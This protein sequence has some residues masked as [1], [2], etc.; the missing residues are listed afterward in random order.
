[1]RAAALLRVTGKADEMWMDESGWSLSLSVKP[2]RWQTWVW[3]ASKLWVVFSHNSGA[4]YLLYLTDS[5][6]DMSM[7]SNH[8]CKFQS[9]FTFSSISY[10]DVK[11]IVWKKPDMPE[12]SLV[13]VSV[14]V[15]GTTIEGHAL[16]SPTP[17]FSTI[18]AACLCRFDSW[19]LSNS[20]MLNMIDT[21]KPWQ[22]QVC[23]FQ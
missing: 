12:T 18:S 14:E 8:L 1:M 10:L 21:I 3:D 13:Q 2:S 5:G 7:S 11:I 20:T 15:F 6:R 4:D 9:A 17:L 19:I 23:L 22:T 16:L